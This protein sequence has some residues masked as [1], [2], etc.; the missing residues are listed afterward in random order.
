MELLALPGVEG[1]EEVCLGGCD[2]AFGGAQQLRVRE[3]LS[4]GVSATAASGVAT[5]KVTL[6]TR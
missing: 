4:Y 1:G 5:R 6:S 2:R 3:L